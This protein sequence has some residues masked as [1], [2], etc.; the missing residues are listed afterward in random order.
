M[1]LVTLSGTYFS[2][3]LRGVQFRKLGL[4]L[5]LV[6]PRGSA[7]GMS[8]FGAIA[9]VLGGNLGTGNIAGIA[10]ALTTGG[11]GALFWMWIMAFLGSILK[12]VGS[13]L[14]VTYRVKNAEGVYVGGPMY[15]LSKGLKKPFI[16]KIYCILLIC[17]AITTG[18]MVQVNSLTLPLGDA[19]FSPLLFSVLMAGLLAITIL[20][21]MKRFSHVVSAV[22]PFMALVYLGI[23]S[24]ILMAHTSQI[25]PALENIVT[26][27]FGYKPL[28][29][30]ALGYSLFA[31][32]QSGFDRGLFA[33][34][35]GLGLA[36]IL[37]APVTTTS[38]LVP[39]NAVAQGVMSVLSPLIV[40]CVCMLTGLVLMVTDAWQV[41]G[42]ESTNQCM[43]AF[44]VGLGHSKAGIIVLFTL[45]FFAFTTVLTWSFCAGRAVA[46]LFGE[47]YVHFFQIFFV[48]VVPLG[49]LVSVTL[50]W[51]L[52][53]VFLNLML[54]LNVYALWGLRRPVI[55]ATRDFLKKHAHVSR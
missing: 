43:E 15:Y 51:Q 32:L 40:M 14:G 42:L 34:D 17:G 12:Y 25:M 31:A 48:A 21:G 2:W 7:T 52:A 36:A 3:V 50:A 29:G 39:S 4:A 5:R 19:G 33:T 20:G 11:P 28:V 46:Y 41:P 10:V 49:G 54:L 45:F 13:Y 18:N 27:A 26:C 6:S 37:H 16:A 55:E 38:E 9:A 30:G 8:S 44:C 23:C 35:S 22:V 1:P 53:D 24:Y 47:R